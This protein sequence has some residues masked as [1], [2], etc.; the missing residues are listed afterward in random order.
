MTQTMIAAFLSS[1]VDFLA[2]SLIAVG[3]AIAAALLFFHL[4]LMSYV[5][6]N[7]IFTSDQK[8][9]FNAKS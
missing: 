9:H 6:Y 7:H 1:L 4:L 3:K 2:D 8:L 5:Q